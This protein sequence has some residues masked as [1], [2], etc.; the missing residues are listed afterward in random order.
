MRQ[1]VRIILWCV[2]F[3]PLGVGVLFCYALAF[4]FGT[5]LFDQSAW[6]QAGQRAPGQSEVAF[7]EQCVRG[8]M[9]TYLQWRLR[10][11]TERATVI[12]LLGPPDW[13]GIAKDQYDLGLCNGGIDHAELLIN[14]GSHG[15]VIA[16][17]L[18]PH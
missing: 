10:Q 9:A 8:R 15:T 14:Y 16:T 17:R 4:P 18:I 6:Q 12:E 5:A 1:I 2:L 13:S 7:Y 3:L 11:G